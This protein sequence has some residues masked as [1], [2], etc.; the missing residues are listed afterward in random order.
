MHGVHMAAGGA[1]ARPRRIARRNRRRACRSLRSGWAPCCEGRERGETPV[2]A[3]R[4]CVLSTWAAVLLGRLSACDGRCMHKAAR[5]ASLRPLIG[6]H[7]SFSAGQMA[8]CA[9]ACKHALAAVLLERRARVWGA[10]HAQGCKAESCTLVWLNACFTS[11]AQVSAVRVGREACA[12]LRDRGELG[13]RC[14][15]ASRMHAYIDLT[16][17]L[18]LDVH[19]RCGKFYRWGRPRWCTASASPFAH[20]RLQQSSHLRHLSRHC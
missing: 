17:Y 19:L 18:S 1:A 8:L 16:I 20:H 13:A 3:V 10:M 5:L 6:M 11:A 4:S 2:R 12:R 14:M 15:H 9:L 7:A